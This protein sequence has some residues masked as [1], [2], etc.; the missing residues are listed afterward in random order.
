MDIKK[1]SPFLSVSPQIGPSDLGILVSQGFR[2]VICNRP[3]GEADDQPATD[4]LRAA[5][6]R[7]GLAF[8][9]QPVKSGQVTDDDVAAFASLLEAAE[10]PVLAFCRTGTRSI[11]LW[12]LSEARHLSPD[13]VLAAAL[14]QGYDLE[15]LSLAE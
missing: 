10:G 12:A 13:A 5:A 8:H 4:T 14:G 3:E 2:T 9:H 15:G 1:I 7:N 6:Q 11:T